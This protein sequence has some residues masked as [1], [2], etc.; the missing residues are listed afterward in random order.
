LSLPRL[1]AVAEA[2]AKE[3]PLAAVPA[4]PPEARL[5]QADLVDLPAV[6]PPVADLVDLPV[7]DLLAADAPRR[8]IRLSIPRTAKFPTL[9]KLARNPTT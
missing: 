9:R 5:L 2:E 4:E 3:H 8:P 6:A 1:A 7:V